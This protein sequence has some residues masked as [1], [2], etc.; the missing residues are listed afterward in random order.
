MRVQLSQR[1]SRLRVNWALDQPCPVSIADSQTRPA[2]AQFGLGGSCRGFNPRAAFF[3]GA[4]NAGPGAAAYPKFQSAPRV[5]LRGDSFCAPDPPCVLRFQSAPR[6]L[7]R[8]DVRSLVE[9][10]N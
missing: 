5:L 6:V 1:V 9:T 8:G 3:C 2:V 7:L 10:A 4:T